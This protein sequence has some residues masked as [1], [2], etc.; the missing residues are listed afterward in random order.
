MTR[1]GWALFIAMAIIWGIPYLLIKIAVG[2]ITPPTLVFARTAIGALLLIPLAAARGELAPLFPYW[3]MILAYTAAEV[4]LPWVLLSDAERRLPSSL[5]GLLVAAVPLIG[6]LLARLTGSDERFG[7]RRLLGLLLGLAG[8][9]ALVGL[10]VSGSNLAA[11]GEVGLVALGYAIGPLI[12]ARRLSTVPA[13]GVVAASLV[14]TTL[15]YAPFGL[16]QMPSTLPSTRVL[17]AV[18]IL[19]LVC[20]AVAFL[21]FFA[22]ISEVGPVR[23]TVITY[24]NPAVALALGILLLREPFTLGAGAGFVLILLGSFLATRRG[25]GVTRVPDVA[26]RDAAAG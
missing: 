24:F 7:G 16:A 22:L 5:T 2:Q 12:I 11:V 25:P 4:A 19:G 21:L 18:G 14:L 23:A 13:L 9:G 17:V 15:L 10:D 26:F 6:V 20:T 1:R 8:V 3:R